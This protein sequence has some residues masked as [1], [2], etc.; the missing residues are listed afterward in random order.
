MTCSDGLAVLQDVIC[1]GL[2]APHSTEALEHAVQMSTAVYSRQ[3]TPAMAEAVNRAVLTMVRAIAW[4]RADTRARLLA[5]GFTD[6]PLPPADRAS[7]PDSGTPGDGLTPAERAFVQLL[8]RQARTA[9]DSD[10]DSGD[11][12]DSGR[13]VKRPTPR[14]RHPPQGSYAAV[15]PRL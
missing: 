9:S 10:S 6:D 11:S 5:M 1:T 4:R 14:P 7:I 15:T 2:A 12:G 8:Y 13:K 3:T